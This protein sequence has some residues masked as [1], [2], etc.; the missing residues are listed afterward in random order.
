MG[1]Q[2]GIANVEYILIHVFGIGIQY[3][4]IRPP[5]AAAVNGI[6]D[7][8]YAEKFEELVLQVYIGKEIGAVDRQV[9]IPGYQLPAVDVGGFQP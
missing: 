6:A 9:G 5:D 4:V 7:Q 8:L 1:L 2:P 3:F